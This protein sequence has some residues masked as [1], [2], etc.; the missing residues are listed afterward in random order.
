M[1]KGQNSSGTNQK[2][3]EFIEIWFL[4]LSKTLSLSFSFFSVANSYIL[5]YNNIRAW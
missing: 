1:E 4:N 5:T 2:H 3:E